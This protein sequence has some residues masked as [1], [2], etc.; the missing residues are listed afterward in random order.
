M[1]KQIFE[2]PT[3]C[4]ERACQWQRLANVHRGRGWDWLRRM[5]CELRYERWIK[6]MVEQANHNH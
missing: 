2:R 1:L 5:R 6:R 3:S 4:Y